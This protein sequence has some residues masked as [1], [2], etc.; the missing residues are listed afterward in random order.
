[1]I[2]ISKYIVNFNFQFIIINFWVKFNV[3]CCY[4]ICRLYPSEVCAKRINKIFE[5]RV[6]E[7][8]WTWKNVSR[9][10]KEFYWEE[11][12]VL[13]SKFLINYAYISLN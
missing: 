11:F 12:E 2:T 5:Q 8:G 13:N 10:T 1:M 4:S 6:D 3:F 9:S 7:D